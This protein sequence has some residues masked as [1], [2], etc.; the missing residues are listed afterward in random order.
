MDLAGTWHGSR[1]GWCP[2]LDYKASGG[3]I[4]IWEA[5]DV[6]SYYG[7]V[8]GSV[9]AVATIAIT[10]SFN[11]KQI[12][13]ENYL[14]TETDRWAKIEEEVADV[15]DKINP[16][17]I[18]MSGTDG[19]TASENHYIAAISAY[20]KYMWNCRIATDKLYALVSPEDCLQIEELLKE[21]QTNADTLFE[22]SNELCKV[23]KNMRDL[24]D[25]DIM[26]HAC[27]VEE[28]M[29]GFFS[30]D[31]LMACREILENS[32]NLRLSD[33]QKTAE[34]T[35]QKLEDIYTGSYRGLLALKVDT[36]TLIY[37]EIQENADQILRFGGKSH[38]DT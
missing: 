24:G 4:T 8:V 6:L 2:Y 14:K 19:L 15:L 12:Q 20:Q 38:A 31:E 34:I 36:F 18:L 13:R 26:Q 1:V 29:P 17:R 28:S 11:R 16:W 23:Y 33:L 21:I 3:Y 32:E 37:A 5:S 25:R 7:M 27:E 30:E 9:I 10:I 22:I 35:G